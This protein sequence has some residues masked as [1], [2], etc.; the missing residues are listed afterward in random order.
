MPDAERVALIRAAIA[1]AEVEME[2]LRAAAAA[3]VVSELETG[4]RSSRLLDIRH[5]RLSL[6]DN[7]E[8]LREA[9]A[10]IGETR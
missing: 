8:G 5:R 4:E 10:L 2:H 9:L 6:A 1:K 7:L 3:E